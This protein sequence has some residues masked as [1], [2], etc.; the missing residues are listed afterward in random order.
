MDKTKIEGVVRHILTFVGGILVMQ[1]V[2][3]ESVLN[4]VIGAAVTLAG[5]IWSI[6][7]KK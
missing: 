4:E 3:E 2:L 7:A 5:V 1:G 6:F